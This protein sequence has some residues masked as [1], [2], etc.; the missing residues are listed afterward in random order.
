MRPGAARSGVAGVLAVLVLAALMLL[1]VRGCDTD[2]GIDPGA[3]PHVDPT[4]TVPPSDPPASSGLYD[5][6]AAARTALQTWARPDLPYDQWWAELEPLLSPQGR[7]DYA[8]TDP[9]VVPQLEI[10]GKGRLETE[11][12]DTSATVWFS[13]SAGR[14]GVRLAR[15]TSTHP[16]LMARIYF[17]TSPSSS[18]PSGDDLGGPA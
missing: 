14:Y 2:P 7:Q 1:G 18:S 4:S 17:P 10:T 13:T 11:H 8:A 3:R 5:P 9:A 15:Q 16:W 12:V 6:V